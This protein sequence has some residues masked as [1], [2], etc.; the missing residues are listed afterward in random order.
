MSFYTPHKRVTVD[1]S[2]PSM[3]KQ[4]FKDECDIHKILSQYKKTGIINHVAPNQPRY[5]DLPSDIDLQTAY[6][7]VLEAES[8]F[9]TLPASIRDRYRNDPE[10]FLAALADPKERSFLEEVGVYQAAPQP[11]PS[12]APSP[13]PVSPPQS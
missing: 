12:P 11:V 1:C 10:R 4:A 2:G 5:L 9:S 6:N 7:V 8:A 13:A 3:T